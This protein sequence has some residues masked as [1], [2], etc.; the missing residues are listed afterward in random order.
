MLRGF[1]TATAGMISQQ[2]RMEMLSN[3]LSN[4]N[5]P[6]YKADQ[7]SLRAFPELLMKRMEQA[8]IPTTKPINFAQQQTIGPLNTGVYLQETAPKHVQG[9]MRPTGNDTDIAILNQQLPE[10]SSIFF[11]VENQ[12]GTPRYTRN[13]NF[14]LD[15]QGYLT[16]NSGQYVL[17]ENNNRIQIQSRQFDMQQDGTILENGIVNS[18]IGIAFAPNAYDLIRDGNGLYRLENNEA[19]PQAA[20]NPGTVFQ[21]LQGHIE[22]SNVDT[23]QTMT[24]MTSA[25]RAFEANQKVIQAYDTTMQKAANEIGRIN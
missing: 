12:D 25:F 16:T 9:D 14:T 4:A 23:A 17:D 21:V 13:G 6:G 7:S 3:N 22:R 20:G 2:R 11:T 1:Y 24:D 15:Q 5:T 10:G 19:L 18:R 8:N